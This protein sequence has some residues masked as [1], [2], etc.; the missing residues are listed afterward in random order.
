MGMPFISGFQI[1]IKTR[2]YYNALYSN[3]QDS[4]T[5]L[6]VELLRQNA[7]RMF[8]YLS[9][10]VLKYV[11][12]RT[13]TVVAKTEY[14]LFHRAVSSDVAELKDIASTSGSGVFLV[15][16]YQPKEDL[17]VFTTRSGVTI[18]GPIAVNNGHRGDKGLDASANYGSTKKY[19]PPVVQIHGLVIQILEAKVDP[20]VTPVL[21]HQLPIPFTKK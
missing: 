15:H 10:L 4:L 20:V 18:Q 19:K 8:K 3:D 5:L 1:C 7:S 14:K 13:Q 12:S 16:C 2:Y 9:R 11:K 21:K 6:L 17:K